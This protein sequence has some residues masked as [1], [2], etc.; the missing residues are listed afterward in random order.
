ME[1]RYCAITLKKREVGETDRLYTLYT[2]EAGKVQAKAVGVRRQEAKLASQLETL[3]YGFVMVVKG[4]GL[5]KIAG[6][7]AENTFPFLRQELDILQRVLQVIHSLE[8][9]VDWEEKD[10]ALFQLLLTY[11]TLGNDLARA[12]EKAKFFLLSEAFLVQLFAHL[13]YRMETAVCS[14]SGE[15][16][17]PGGRYF[18]SPGAGG[19]VSESHSVSRDQALPISENAIKLIRIILANKLESIPRIQ[20]A[21]EG[22]REVRQA[23]VHFFR[24]ISR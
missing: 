23:S 11:L 14:V 17:T 10:T 20:V 2:Q 19:I 9:L 3:T 13:G 15:K 7:V 12:G 21:A 5:G 8:R 6:A 4:K 24:W 16:L 1:L 18:F 22:V